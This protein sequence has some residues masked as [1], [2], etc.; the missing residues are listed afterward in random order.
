M[1]AD[2]R[3]LISVTPDVIEATFA[4]RLREVREAA[5]MT[6]QD[7]ADLMRST[8]NKIHRS[9]IGKIECGGRTVTI[10][11]AVQLAAYLEVDLA[12]LVAPAGHL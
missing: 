8:G 4:R 6:Q 10:G 3:A 5:G 9:T 7:L 12:G 2:V 11:E 1:T